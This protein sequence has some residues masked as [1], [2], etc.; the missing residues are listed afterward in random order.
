LQECR[1]RRRQ[2]RGIER[3]VGGVGCGVWGVG[4]SAIHRGIWV[5][6]FVFDKDVLIC[7]LTDSYETCLIR[8]GHD[9]FIWDMTHSY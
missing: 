1:R 2:R 4:G 8:M 7:D 3:V 9:S 5:D 6:S